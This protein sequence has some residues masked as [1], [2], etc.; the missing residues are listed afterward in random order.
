MKKSSSSRK[1]LRVET[2]IGEFRQTPRGRGFSPTWF[3]LCLRAIQNGLGFWGRK[4]PCIPVPKKWD[5]MLDVGTVFGKSKAGCLGTV[6]DSPKLKLRTASGQSR[7]KFG[8]LF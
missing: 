5:R 7:T 2:G 8:N 4:W 1:K 6:L 3:N